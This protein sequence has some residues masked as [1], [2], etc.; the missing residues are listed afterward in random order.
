[1]NKQYLKRMGLFLIL[2]VLVCLLRRTPFVLALDD[3]IYLWAQQLS[4]SELWLKFWYVWTII[5]SGRVVHAVMLV[6][7]VILLR[8]SFKPS[9]FL[10]VVIV[11]FL[12]NIVTPLKKFFAIERP[13]CLASFYPEPKSFSFPSGHAFSSVLLFFF[14]P[15]L[16]ALIVR[17]A[18]TPE[19]KRYKYYQSLPFMLSGILLISFSRVFIGVH[20]FSDI[21]AGSF[22]GFTFSY[23]CLWL[24]EILKIGQNHSQN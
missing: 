21:V 5:G 23:F 20:W 13:I 12:G 3:K 1:M 11:Y 17:V 2:F 7:A 10:Y 22:L 9:S 4:Y 8:Y 14:I 18:Q 6:T 15:C 19:P 16:M 24:Y